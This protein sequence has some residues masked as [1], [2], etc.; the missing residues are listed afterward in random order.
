MHASGRGTG[1]VEVFSM[2]SGSLAYGSK[3]D[4]PAHRRVVDYQLCSF[5][6]ARWIAQLQFSCDV[7]LPPPIGFS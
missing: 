2:Y 6:L 4:R 3:L 7:L 1:V 5:G